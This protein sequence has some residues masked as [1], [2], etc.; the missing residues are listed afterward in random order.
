MEKS[1]RGKRVEK[2]E[3]GLPLKRKNNPN[4]KRF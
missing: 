2:C 4:E 1:K 3:R